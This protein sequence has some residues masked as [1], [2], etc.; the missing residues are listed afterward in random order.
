MRVFRLYDGRLARGRRPDLAGRLALADILANLRR[1][2]ACPPGTRRRRRRFIVAAFAAIGLSAP[3]SASAVGGSANVWVDTDGGSCKRTAAKRSYRDGRACGGLG[4]AYRKA[5]AGDKILIAPGTYGWQLI[6]RGSKVV[7]IEN[8]PGTRPLLG[9]T[10]VDASN[11]KLAGVTIR[12]TDDPWGTAAATLH[13]AGNR[14]FLGRVR[15]NSLNSPGRQGIF[16][17]G[18]RN[19]FQG[20]ST[21][22]VVDE[23]GALVGGSHTTFNHF[24]FHDVRLTSSAVHNECV[25]SNGPN[26]TIKNSHFWQCATMDLFITRGDWWGQPLYG[27]VTLIN[28]VFEHSTMEGASSWHYYSLGINGGI[29]Q[30]MRNW[31]VINN[32]F[33][34]EVSGSGTPAPGTIWANNVGS[35]G[36]YPHATFSHNVGKK[37]SQSDTRVSPAV[38]CGLPACGSWVTAAQRWVN[39]ARH[40]FHL[41]RG[42]PAVNAGSA[43]HAPKR[44]KDGK[45]RGSGSRPEAGAYEYR[46]G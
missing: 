36:C 23:K 12:R 1:L 33:E 19:V 43:K 37:C 21:Y 41:K 15:V 25:Y 46:P 6:P 20:G 35:W 24:K 13:V 18:D 16:A 45:R 27:G 17:D 26:L 30:E 3:G 39:P 5:A 22:N 28:N 38:S 42:A 31:T 44:D 10:R 7:K 11:I 34:T 32:T 14:N 4:G 29:I 9:P 8:A 40:N 2:P